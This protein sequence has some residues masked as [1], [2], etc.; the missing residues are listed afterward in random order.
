MATKEKQYTE[1]TL[2]KNTDTTS[3]LEIVQRM[4]EKYPASA[5]VMGLLL[6]DWPDAEIALVKLTVLLTEGLEAN[7]VPIVHDIIKNALDNYSLSLTESQQKK[8]S[9]PARLGYFLESLIA[10]TS[11]LSGLVITNVKGEDWKLLS[12]ETL[13]DWLRV[14]ASLPYAANKVKLEQKENDEKNRKALYDF[15]TNERMK[16]VLQRVGYEKQVVCGGM[17]SVL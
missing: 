15:L 16:I 10:D 17:S 14:K 13:C 1:F 2:K 11:K 5:E 9:D 3:Y 7:G 4:N 8:Y 6:L 12:G